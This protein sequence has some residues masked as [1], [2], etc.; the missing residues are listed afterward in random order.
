MDAL[1]P[2]NVLVDDMKSEDTEVR[3]SAMR[4][5]KVVAA[6]LGAERTRK[7][8][9]PFLNEQV[10]DDDEVLLVM[11]DELGGFVD[12]VGGP[13]ESTC[14]MGPLGSLATVEETVVRDKAVESACTVIRGLSS[15]AVIEHVLPVIQRLTQGDWF[16]ARVSACGM[17]AAA[18]ARV[19]DA[20]ARTTLRSLYATLC[21]DET[22]M[23][24]RAASKHIGSLVGAVEHEFVISELLPLFNTLAG[25][26]QDSVR[27][28]AIEN[29]VAFAR[30]LSAHENV[31]HVMPLVKHCAGDKS[32]R[33]RNNVAKE[34]FTLS[35]CV[36]AD[37]TRG[38]LLP[39]FVTL[40]KDPEGEVR[41]SAAK[42]IAGYA[43]LVGPDRFVGDVFPAARDLK[44]DPLQNVRCALA[45]SFMDVAAT[46]GLRAD[47]ADSSIIPVIMELLKDEAPEVRLKVL[48]ALGKLVN[49]VARPFLESVLLPALL[50]LAIDP[51]WR[52]REKVIDQLP[53]LA[54][55][56]GAETFESQ[57]LTVYLATYTDQVNAVRMAATRSLESLARCLGA[58]WTRAKL[59]PRLTALFSPD[60]SYLQRITVLYAVRGVAT[61]EFR[62][63][64]NESLPLL[65][66]GLSD[67]VPNVR[68]VAAQILA[69][70]ADVFEAARRA[71]IRAAL[72]ALGSDEDIDVRH[73]ASVAAE[74]F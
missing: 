35:D 58:A 34:F 13:A 63:I 65:L 18:Y 3:I 4:K 71:D 42:N 46:G 14:L 15:N 56:L 36:G 55:S 28:L 52:V 1:Y 30:V 43:R 61:P 11:A 59:V 60:A 23:V 54:K 8:L 70:G 7:E 5:L 22:P 31:R 17:Y 51:L 50:N 53:L 33:V 19:T 74:A 6:A 27:L 73:F 10:E 44:A 32:W 24:R 48:E 9:I 39:L 67:A 2:I 47:A 64:A 25:D 37:V 20:A 12:L 57:L 29:C 45:E 26:D 49:A 16:T 62:D 66:R 69:A 41:A 72:A 68:F 40:L 38:E 21:Q